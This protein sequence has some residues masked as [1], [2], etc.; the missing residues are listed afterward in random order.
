M[1]T[2]RT[3][4]LPALK[5][6]RSYDSL[7]TVGAFICIRLVKSKINLW[8]SSVYINSNVVNRKSIFITLLV[9]EQD[10]IYSL[11]LMLKTGVQHDFLSLISRKQWFL[12]ESQAAHLTCRY[13]LSQLNADHRLRH[14]ASFPLCNQ[15]HLWCPL[16][17]I[18]A[19]SS[20]SNSHISILENLSSITSQ[21]GTFLLFCCAVIPRRSVGEP[22]SSW[23]AMLQILAIKPLKKPI[24]SA[25]VTPPTQYSTSTQGPAVRGRHLVIL[26]HFLDS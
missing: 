26:E 4:K 24:A 14:I 18:R 8:F 25:W 10:E 9:G 6:Y 12:W 7:T 15:H 22:V 21:L 1:S 13:Y 3:W 20:S 5:L 11:Q 16:I 2:Y 19:H 17:V 23:L